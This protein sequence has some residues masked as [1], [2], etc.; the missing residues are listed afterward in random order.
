MPGPLHSMRARL[1][2]IPLVAYL[3]RRLREALQPLGTP[4]SLTPYGFQ[5][6]IQEPTPNGDRFSYAKQQKD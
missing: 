6:E 3:Y 4:M 1:R 2:S 5:I